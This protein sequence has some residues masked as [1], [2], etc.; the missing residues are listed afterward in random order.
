MD[1]FD[2]EGDF[3]FAESTEERKAREIRTQQNELVPIARLPPEILADILRSMRPD[4]FSAPLALA[5][6][7]QGLQPVPQRRARVP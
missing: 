4:Y 1:V 5:E 7:H 2:I 6:R 3:F